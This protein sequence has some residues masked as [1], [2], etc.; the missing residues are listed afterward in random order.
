MNSYIYIYTI[1]VLKSH[2]IPLPSLTCAKVSK[3]APKAQ[4]PRISH[5]QDVASVPQCHFLGPGEMY[6]AFALRSPELQP[7]EPRRF[8]EETWRIG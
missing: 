6:D 3:L 2:S 5:F 4:N 7:F 1:Y 8:E